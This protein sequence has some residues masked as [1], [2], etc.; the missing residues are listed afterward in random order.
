MSK[1]KQ[2]QWKVI[3]HKFQGSPLT[4]NFLSYRYGYK[5]PKIQEMAV[6]YQWL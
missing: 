1:M 3:L 6:R 2:L 4:E 5:S